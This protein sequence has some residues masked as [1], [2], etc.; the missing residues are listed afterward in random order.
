MLHPAPIKMAPKDDLITI[1]IFI[2]WFS[3]KSDFLADLSSFLRIRVKE[4][5][6]IN[7]HTPKEISIHG[8]QEVVTRNKC[9]TRDLETS[10][11]NEIPTEKKKVKANTKISSI[12]KYLLILPES[13]GN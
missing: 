10:P 2:I 8:S 1:F 6:F 9:P 12:L 4:M 13:T 5:Q 3:S 11:D 7:I